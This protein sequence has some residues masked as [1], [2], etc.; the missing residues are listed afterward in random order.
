MSDDHQRELDRSQGNITQLLHDYSDGDQV[1]WDALFQAV[2]DDL[3]LI[4]RAQRRK[5]PSSN[6]LDTAALVNEAY[7]RL[8]RQNDPDW[9]N[10]RHF[11]AVAAMA[12]RQILLDYARRR[13]AAKRGGDIDPDVSP[14]DVADKAE[15]TRLL[16]LD[17]ALEELEKENPRQVRI[18]ECRYFAGLTEDQTAEA[19]GISPRTVQRGWAEARQ[20]LR[21]RLSDDQSD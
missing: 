13:I 10:R 4:A 19:L 2:Y 8:A 15:A 14:E 17:Q 18:V 5:M 20:W 9:A 12:S 3:L 1:A 16:D 11:F 6:T 7:L 21:E